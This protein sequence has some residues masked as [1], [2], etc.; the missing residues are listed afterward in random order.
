MR[1]VRDFDAYTD[2]ELRKLIID[3]ALPNCSGMQ[4]VVRAIKQ[5]YNA[6]DRE[7]LLWFIRH[8]PY[9]GVLWAP[10]CKRT[11]TAKEA[12]R[13]DYVLECEQAKRQK[14]RIVATADKP[15]QHRFVKPL[16]AR[17][18]QLYSVEPDILAVLR[19]AG[20]KPVII[21]DGI[22]GVSKVDAKIKAAFPQWR[23]VEAGNV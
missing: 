23:F 12:A 8:P 7:M 9:N 20:C 3:N 6:C 14:Q 19:R 16:L 11:L 2:A 13:E 10:D 5:K 21:A 1:E 18:A 22:V 17:P 4:S 15:K